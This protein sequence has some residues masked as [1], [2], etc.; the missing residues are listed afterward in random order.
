MV[1]GINLGYNHGTAY[2]HTSGTVGAVLEAGIAGIDGLALSAG[3][4]GEFG[5]WMAWAARE[6]S[7]P[8]WERLARI[9][10]ELAS[11]LIEAGPLGVRSMPT[12]PMMPTSR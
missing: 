9:G 5:P 2:L 4:S 7:V 1:S 11:G 6:E 3:G 12:S 8:M 10:A